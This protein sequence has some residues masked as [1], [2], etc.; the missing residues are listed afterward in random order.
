MQNVLPP[1]S[2]WDGK[3]DLPMDEGSFRQILSEIQPGTPAPGAPAA[4]AGSTGTVQKAPAP[5]GAP[6]NGG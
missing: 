4:T 6:K 5:A 3:T 2:T 1:G